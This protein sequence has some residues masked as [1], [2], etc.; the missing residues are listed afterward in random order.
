MAR[1]RNRTARSR[2]SDVQHAR[3][4]TA[5]VRVIGEHGY[6]GMS[7]ARVTGAARV[8][9]R[10]FY[11]LFED[12]EDC[13]LAVF[14]TGVS[15]AT[16]VVEE[17]ASGQRT[18]REQVR[19][20]LSALLQ[21]IG[22]EPVL[23]SLLIVHALAAG[24]R[25]LARRTLVL[26]TLTTIVDQGRYATGAGRVPAPLTAEGVVGAVLSV[27]HARMLEH[28]DR[29][30]LELLNP[31]MCMIVL[32]YL[33]TA[34]AAKELDRPAPEIP[35]TRAKH[36]L[37]PLEGLQMRMTYRTL[38][39]LAV[40]ASQPGASNREI[41]RRAGVFDQGQ[42]SKLLSRL[43]RLGLIRNTG[44]GPTKGEPNAWTLTPKGHE[45]QQAVTVKTSG[46]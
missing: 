17:A 45:V 23:G 24:P 35:H 32:P 20:G 12:R 4:L 36:A 37:D 27:I 11:E 18:W 40:I 7:V 43:E 38:R 13:F 3:M 5:A 26:D 30:P 21:F 39:V 6:G 16:A 41:G 42:I 8:S 2:V 10:T 28:T 31:L 46:A 33:S 29:P 44:E 25:V 14:E 1:T 15:R 22:D 34:A 9:R 19:I